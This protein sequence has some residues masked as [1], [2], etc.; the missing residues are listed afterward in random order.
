MNNFTPQFLSGRVKT[1]PPLSADSGRYVFIG[2]GNAEPN[3]GVPVGISGYKYLAT[4]DISGTRFWSSSNT[5][6]IDTA[7]TVQVSGL[8]AQTL[9]YAL[10]QVTSTGSYQLGDTSVSFFD[11]PGG[12][13]AVLPDPLTYTGKFLTLV[14]KG[15]SS[16]DLSGNLNGMVTTKTVSTNAS[17][18][19]ISDGTSWYEN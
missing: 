7:N 19:L 17:F 16:I 11:S 8:S 14:N 5:I 1:V 13:T 2:Q 9:A 15:V 12:T 6:Y 18:T 4:S 10:E 3:L